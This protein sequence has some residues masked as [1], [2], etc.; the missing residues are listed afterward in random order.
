MD[1]RNPV[2][3]K[4]MSENPIDSDSISRPPSDPANP[5]GKRKPVKKTKTAK[6][7]GLAKKPAGKPKADRTNKKA[8]VIAMM[9]R[10]TGATLPE[11]MKPTGWQPHTIRGFVSILG[12]KGGEKIDSSKNAAGERT[13]KIGKYRQATPRPNAA[14]A[15]RHGRRSCFW[16]LRSGGFSSPAPI[17]EGSLTPTTRTAAASGK[18][19]EGTLCS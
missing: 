5:K 1:D 18:I 8:E 15:S 2:K 12:S 7:V 10:A 16:A 6:K 13:Y 19:W 17:R 9:K 11:I 14:S 3:E 4:P